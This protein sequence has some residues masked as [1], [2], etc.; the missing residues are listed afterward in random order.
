MRR[1]VSVL[2]A[3]GDLR[4]MLR[5]EQ[6]GQACVASR[7][8][9]CAVERGPW[10]PPSDDQGGAA[11]GLF[12][13]DG[14]LTRQVSRGCRC[15]AELLAAGDVIVPAG[16]DEQ[17]AT[18]D[19]DVT[20]SA[21]IATQVAVLDRRW[22]GRMAP[23]PKVIAAVSARV[24]RRAARSAQLLTIVQE[25]RLEE[26]LWLVLWF[27]ADRFGTVHRDGVHLRLPLTHE[28][29]SH[30]ACA[31]R[32][33]VSSAFMRLQRMGRVRREADGWVLI[34]PAPVWPGSIS[35]SGSSSAVRTPAQDPP[36]P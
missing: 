9:V 1:V 24:L 5:P 33:S 21:V 25:P 30:V 29:L 13:L 7:A 23:Y 31:R 10:I 8:R 4:T 26:R 36:H 6:A 3:D 2:D 35:E 17:P 28:A 12:V 22:I 14:L 15:A 20:W 32:P 11:V 27:L 19:F 18:L 16:A 34:A